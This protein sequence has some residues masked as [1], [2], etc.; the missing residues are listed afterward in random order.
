[1]VLIPDLHVPDPLANLY[2]SDERRNLRPWETEL[3]ERIDTLFWEFFDKSEDPDG[4]NRRW[5]IERDIDWDAVGNQPLNENMAGLLESFYAVESYLP[6]FA[7]KGLAF[8]R[9][10]L[11]LA[12]NHINWSYEEIKHSRAL[13]LV[14]VRS[15]ARTKQQVVEFRRSVWREVWMAPFDTPRRMI[16]YAA[17]Q[18]KA[19]HRNYEQLRKVALAQGATGAAGAIRLVSKDEAFHHAFYRDVMKLYIEYDEAGTAA[20]LLYVASNFQ[21]PA[22]HLLPDAADRIRSLVRNRIVSRRSLRDEAILPTI[23]SIGFRDL[24]ELASVADAEA[25][26]GAA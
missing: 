2:G 19:T 25:E 6:D 14:L 8:Y 24:E 20:D 3:G 13:E 21:M 16:A 9:R 4:W 10:L 17:M 26:E 23:N 1:M 5:V 22:Q 15:G 12:H 11:G 18:E 7:G